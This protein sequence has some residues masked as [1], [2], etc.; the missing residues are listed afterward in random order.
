MISLQ[1]NNYGSRSSVVVITRLAPNLLRLCNIVTILICLP[2][3]NHLVVPYLQ[4]VVSMK[5][6]IGLGVILNL[7]ALIT[8]I[9]LERFQSAIANPLPWLLIPAVILSIGE[10]LVV[11][12][13]EKFICSNLYFCT[14]CTCTYSEMF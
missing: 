8:S 4:N 10:M 14:S 6:H 12:T 11:T 9:C 7:G 2:V 13:G 5:H 1:M 3:M